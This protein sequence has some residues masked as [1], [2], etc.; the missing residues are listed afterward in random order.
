MKEKELEQELRNEWRRW[1]GRVHEDDM[2]SFVDFAEEVG[3]FKGYTV[4]LERNS[5]GDYKIRFKK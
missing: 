5:W 4:E 1:Q 2:M 3:S